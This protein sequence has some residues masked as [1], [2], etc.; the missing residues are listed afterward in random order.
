M[1][2]PSAMTQLTVSSSKK[3]PFPKEGH[4]F[5]A[6]IRRRS[7]TALHPAV[8]PP[9]AE[10]DGH[11]DRQPDKKPDPRVERQARH[12]GE[13]DHDA[14]DGNERNPRR[15][16]RTMQFGPPNS[17]KPDAGAH[18]HEG[19]KRADAYQFSQYPDRNDRGKH[20][21][22]QAAGNRRDPWG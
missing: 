11:A 15:T 7:G 4:D 2:R 16:E 13:G 1:P 5:L 6:A 20:C 8:I 14:H 22:E 18:N 9:V 19:Q 3:T 12:Q 17:Q 21:Y 10:V